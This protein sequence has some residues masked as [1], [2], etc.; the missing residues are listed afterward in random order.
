[1][2]AIKDDTTLSRLLQIYLG[3]RKKYFTKVRDVYAK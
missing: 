1:M 3:T 2:K